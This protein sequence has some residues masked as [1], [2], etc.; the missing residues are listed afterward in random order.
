[1]VAVAEDAEVAGHAAVGLE[2][3]PGQQL[4]ALLEAQPLDVEV[5]HPDTPG[6][7][8]GV[9]AVVGG[10]PLG[11]ALEQLA[12]SCSVSTIARSVSARSISSI[13]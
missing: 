2:H 8:V 10:H 3:D 11:E 9:L 6:V 13:R 1:M 12:R 7:V 5:R 4:L